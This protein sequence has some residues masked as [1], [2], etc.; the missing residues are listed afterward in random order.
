MKVTWDLLEQFCNSGARKGLSGWLGTLPHLEGQEGS[1]E[2]TVMRI[3]S[4]NMALGNILT[5]CGTYLVPCLEFCTWEMW[6]GAG[7]RE[8]AVTAESF[9]PTVQERDWFSGWHCIC[10]LGSYLD[11]MGLVA[12]GLPRI[13]PVELDI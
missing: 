7:G 8:T 1:R 5:H 11:N 2:R 6:W 12:V 3:W 9:S 10:S 4:L 13:S